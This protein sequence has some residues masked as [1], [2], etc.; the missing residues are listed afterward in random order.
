MNTES[1]ID[2]ELTDDNVT[3]AELL[4]DQEA[5]KDYALKAEAGQ[6]QTLL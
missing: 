2:K 6:I 3:M 1:L 5:T 4:T